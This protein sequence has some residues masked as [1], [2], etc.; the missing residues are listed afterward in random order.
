M[1]KDKK[2]LRGQDALRE[3]NVH[4]QKQLELIATL[5]SKLEMVRHFHLYLLRGY[6]HMML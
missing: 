3:M 2:K 1:Y 5:R 4:Y 6:W